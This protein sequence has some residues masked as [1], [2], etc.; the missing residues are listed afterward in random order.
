VEHLFLATFE[1]IAKQQKW[2]KKVWA[3]QVVWL[4]IGKAMA[5]YAAI[6]PEDV[7]DYDK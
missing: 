6:T 2:L 7:T 1:R 4:P 3:T 5:A